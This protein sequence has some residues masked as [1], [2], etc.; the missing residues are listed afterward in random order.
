[1]GRAVPLYDFI[2]ACSYIQPSKM[3]IGT[4]IRSLGSSADL[5][6][7][8]NKAFWDAENAKLRW[9]AAAKHYW[10]DDDVLEVMGDTAMAI[11]EATQLWIENLPGVATMSTEQYAAMR[12]R[13]S[14]LMDDVHQRLVALPAQ[15]KTV[16]VMASMD[17]DLL[18]LPG[19]ND[20][21]DGD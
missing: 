1:M 17:A 12:A 11:K 8:I 6:P 4:Y 3:D 13:V 18:G 19:D 9:M 16:S 15:R 5:P 10:H 20:Q 21:D 14:E 2:E 7:H